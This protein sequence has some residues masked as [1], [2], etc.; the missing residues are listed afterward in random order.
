MLWFWILSIQM[1]QNVCFKMSL[2]NQANIS[3][4]KTMREGMEGYVAS[5]VYC[6]LPCSFSWPLL[7]LSSVHSQFAS[8]ALVTTVPL[9]HTW[10]TDWPQLEAES[11]TCSSYRV[12]YLLLW[13]CTVFRLW[14][15]NIIYKGI[16]FFFFLL[17]TIVTI[18]SK[19][20]MK[21][22]LSLWS[23]RFMVCF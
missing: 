6:G 4:K 11:G 2:Q 1:S 22:L 17:S 10:P 14:I 18:R 3:M 7:H 5:V 19:T 12:V 20:K 8:E 13:K 15:L 16:F 21:T 9:S 23:G